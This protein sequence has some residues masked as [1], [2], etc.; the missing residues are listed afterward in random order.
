[1]MNQTKK[2]KILL[3]YRV[4]FNTKLVFLEEKEGITGVEFFNDIMK[5]VKIF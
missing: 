5:Q 4:F 3:T 2:N 1:M